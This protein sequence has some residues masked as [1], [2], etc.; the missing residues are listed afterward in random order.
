MKKKIISAAIATAMCASMIPAPSMAYADGT[1]DTEYS[2]VTSA[3]FYSE[4]F[5]ENGFVDMAKTNE[6]GWTYNPGNGAAFDCGNNFNNVQTGS[7]M[8]RFC[9]TQWDDSSLELN[10]KQS[11]IAK[12]IDET[13]YDGY[14]TDNIAVSFQ[15]AATA[16][17]NIGNKQDGSRNMIELRTDDGKPFMAFE[18][19]TKDKNSDDITL[20]LIALNESKTE[21]VRYELA[22]GASNI[23]D[24]LHEVTVYVNNDD[25]TYQVKVGAD[26]L[27]IG[28]FGAWIPMSTSDDVGAASQASDAKVGSIK[29]KNVHSS[30]YGGIILDNVEL[31][32]W[33]ELSFTNPAVAPDK[34]MSMWYRMPA[35]RWAQSIPLGNGRIGAMVWGGITSDTLSLS[36]VT[37]WSGEDHRSKNLDNDGST[38]NWAALNN[39]REEM[40]KDTP[41]RSKVT[42]YLS[43]MGGEGNS[44][45]GT[46]RPFGKLEFSFNGMDNA[47]SGYRRSLD[48]ENA[49]STVE[50]TSGGT[51]YT[52]EAIVSNPDQVIALKYSKKGSGKISFDVNFAT[53]ETNGG[54]GTV[55]AG[56]NYLE[57]DGAVY[58][59][60]SVT[61][62]VNT[63][64]YM[65]AVPDGG[66]V[67]Y[68]KTGMHVL[69]A[70]EVV[71]IVSIGTD[72]KANEKYNQNS[73]ENCKNQ[74]DAAV[75]K[76]Y[77]DIKAEH[78]EDV[79]K[80]FNRMKVE[81]GAKDELKSE[82]PTDV[83]YEAIRD[84]AEIDGSFMSLWYQYAR[85]LMIAGSR[86]NSPLPMNLLGIWNDNVACNMAWTCDYH[87]DVNTQMNQWMSNSANLSESELP[88]INYIKN[89]LIPSGQITAEKQYNAEGWLANV[90]TNAWGYAGI[91]KDSWEAFTD[92][93]CGAWIMQ[94][95]MNYYNHTGDKEF[96][97]ESGFYMLKETAKFFNSFMTQYTADDGKTYWVTIPSGS[98]EN[99]YVEIMSTYDI[100]L[101][102]DIFEQTL[103]C[104]DILEGEKYIDGDGSEAEVSKNDGYY[105]AIQEKYA[106]LLDYKITESGTVAEWPFLKNA[107]EKGLTDDGNTNHRHT[108]HLLGLFPYA[109]I[110]PDR[111]PELAAAALES[112]QRRY[113]R[114]DYEHTEW[115]AVMAAAQYA[116]LKDGE[117]AYKY[118]KLE[119]DT[120]TW[121]NLLSISP[122]GI[123]LAPCDVYC[124]D[125]TLGIAQDLAEMLLQS[126]SDRL[127]FLPALPKEWSEGNI[128]GMSA[129]GAFDVD[130]E[131]KDYT[132]KSAKI[133]SKSGNRVNIL[134]N[135]AINWDN[136]AVYDEDGNKL[137]NVT[138]T[139][140]LLSFDT[141]AGKSYTLKNLYGEE[142]QTGKIINDSDPR[143]KYDG[144]SY[145]NERSLPDIGNDI[146]Y[147]QSAG[148]S[149]EFQFV[150]TGIDVIAE[151][152][153]DSKTMEVFIDGESKGKF[154]AKS[155]TPRGQKVLYSV[156]DLDYG[157]HTIK[158]VQNEDGG[159]FEF[160]AFAVRG[161]YS[162]F[163]NDD[164]PMITYGD[165]W[166][167]SENRNMSNFDYMGDVHYATE[168][169]SSLNVEFSGTGIEVVLEKNSGIISA[170]IDGTDY[171]EINV[172]EIQDAS[173]DRRLTVMEISGLA[174]G[175]HTLKLTKNGGDWCIVDGFIILNEG[176]STFNEGIYELSNLDNGKVLSLNNT[177]I[178]T[179]DECAGADNQKW[180][181]DYVDN[182][183]FRLINAQTGMAVSLGSD[184]RSLVQ[185]KIDVN[186]K[187]QIWQRVK[188][189]AGA[190][191][192]WLMNSM[193]GKDGTL[194]A[195]IDGEYDGNGGGVAMWYYSTSNHFFW[196]FEDAGENTVLIKNKLGTYMSVDPS[197]INGDGASIKTWSKLV[198]RNQKWEIK[199]VGD[200]KYVIKQAA[201][202]KAI[203]RS[204]GNIILGSAD[205]DAA[206]WT[207]EQKK[208][209]GVLYCIFTN[210]EDNSEL[211]IGGTKW[212]ISLSDSNSSAPYVYDIH[213]EGKIVDGGEV[214]VSYKYANCDGSIEDG[215]TYKVYMNSSE[216]VV[217]SGTTSESEGFKFEVPS[218]YGTNSVL[219]IEITPSS[220]LGKT[221][222]SF[223]KN[224]HAINVNGTNMSTSVT[225]QEDFS[226][227]DMAAL[228][229][230]REKGFTHSGSTYE[231]SVGEKSG[232][233]NAMSILAKDWWNSANVT[234]DLGNDDNEFEELTG[235]AYVEFD[236]MFDAPNYYDSG[237]KMYVA[238]NNGSTRF[239]AIRLTGENLDVISLSDGRYRKYYNIASG[240]DNVYGKWFNFKF[241]VDT[242]TNKYAVKVNNKFVTLDNGD[243]WF[244]ATADSTSDPG[245]ASTE[246]IGKIVS[247]EFG[248]EWMGANSTLWIDNIKAG[249]YSEMS[250]AYWIVDE[251]SAADGKL[252]YGKTNNMNL[253]V[254]EKQKPESGKIYTA[255]YCD[256]VLKSIKEID[257][258]DIQFD[259]RGVYETTVTMD[260][261]KVGGNYTAKVFVWDD[262]MRPIGDVYETEYN[263]ESQF[264]L[265]NVFSD[266]M[267]LQADEDITV[268]GTGVPNDTVTVTLKEKDAETAYEANCTIAE[269]GTWEVTLDAKE[270]GGDYTM[271]VKCGEETRR[272][273]N[274]IFGDVYLL[275]G[276]SNMEAWLSWIDSQNYAGEKER[277]E[278]S[279]IRTIDLL[280]KGGNGSSN[281]SDNLPEIE[282]NAWAPM[283]FSNANTTSAIG[284]Y[285]AQE[286]NKE[287]GRPIGYIHAAV[288]GTRIDR[289]LENDYVEGISS[290]W[291]L[292]NNR[293]YP[294]RKFKL[295]GVLYYQGES[296]GPEDADSLD[297]SKGMSADQYST[298]MAALIDNYRELFNNE[299]LP[300]YYAQLARYS[301]QNFENIR[302]AQ[303]WALDK[304]TNPNYVRMVSNLDEVGN[305]G[306]VGNTSG[307]ARHDIHPYGKDEVARRFA[308]LAKHDIYGYT[309]SSV[310]G[311]Q[312]KSMET[313]GDKLILTF[314]ADG[315]LDI[316]DKDCY[317]DYKTDEL[318]ESDKLD[319]TVL[320]GFEIAGE[321]GIYY[322]ANAEIKGKTVIL[323]CDEV[324]TPVKARY[325]FGAYPESPNL[326]DGSGLP[327]YTFATEYTSKN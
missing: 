52:R 301:N 45:F 269:D 156:D 112:M 153:S 80:L 120:F 132:I 324:K 64:G 97:K 327:S 101:I 303:V 137:E 50:F 316:L 246:T 317:A 250:G 87:L 99:G 206:K 83:R 268:W 130:F 244:T 181:L 154:N 26:T 58:N 77:S 210:A 103:K 273:T 201:G 6:N 163:I 81:I 214:T 158:V 73:K 105:A 11:A 47:I 189:T 126:H 160:D 247:L 185:E 138:D 155:D 311:P 55:T 304:V 286:L 184:N 238:L 215:S 129:E 110:T 68:D 93:A 100:T 266:N 264:A 226:D 195:Q 180:I 86:E 221:G 9:G 291:S 106:G 256:G 285:F 108:S 141:K 237:S 90:A 194:F 115:T 109:Q 39:L 240:M 65:Q 230:S 104:Y 75:A 234:L 223:S 293:V 229:N 198:G 288:G 7:N 325:A 175:S 182:A 166:G 46:N 281:P 263:V 179:T 117:N 213:T 224:I 265:P 314:E 63:F 1:E 44:N 82:D 208:Q 290:P 277:A 283:T 219:T 271:T 190:N 72:F 255:L 67:T 31:S 216:N 42:Q 95:V 61:N 123:A 88:L 125:G 205:T 5:E 305:F 139:S 249:T 177:E 118:L 167:R 128:E 33:T 235:K 260:V 276:Q 282:G 245:A 176:G 16:D 174:N 49:V 48:L 280:S 162:N 121:P 202:D 85:Y 124:I 287:T 98:P 275:A 164:N 133:T 239:A 135:A 267:M 21:N 23:F 312:Y 107:D 207:I 24:V 54:T 295:S 284:Y 322:S 96:L 300:F 217:A 186:S 19:Y 192:Y 89:I 200:N 18:A 313:D 320:N 157:N 119:A 51:K 307:N 233:D 159:Y 148:S 253:R 146:H 261:P 278:N 319:V 251:F 142:L 173:G 171:D 70:N 69:D 270:C 227:D 212:A 94:E 279:N 28:N 4:D 191:E 222:A 8:I 32:K 242:E 116:R 79:S 14:M 257:S 76:G 36:E 225:A 296:D 168:N 243:I 151:G 169:G 321:D 38:D 17:S 309:D 310:T 59:T 114:N 262:S 232:H 122:E 258:D 12:G 297:S 56:E 40:K 25:N 302:A 197:N 188:S 248:H 218:D 127:E 161:Q 91:G 57:W 165:G 306:S 60:D 292:Y 53:E 323:S 299:N 326:T 259:A 62:G 13:V 150:G 22:K 183:N 102:R 27:D 29:I 78:A 220:K 203:V 231:I 298:I 252:E 318:I 74:L 170:A 272:Y 199:Y 66:T 140:K 149:I 144:F 228:I 178:T 37:D 131:W 193:L 143:I 2:M 172:G 41:D 274:I 134:K 308:L 111:T 187:K 136:V 15:Y 10:L 196:S 241:Y 289:W 145:H 315:D 113:N 204:N 3:P 84:G 236:A 209:N 35:E 30:W 92:T 211:D 152:S 71:V 34:A 147:S 20:N 43:E 294:L 254:I